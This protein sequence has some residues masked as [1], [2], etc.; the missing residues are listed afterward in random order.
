[1]HLVRVPG[2]VVSGHLGIPLVRADQRGQDPDH[3]GLP[4]T[5][6]P[7]QPEHRPGRH[8][9][10][11]PGQRPRATEALGQPLGS[12]DVHLPSPLSRTAYALM[13]TPYP[14]TTLYAMT[15]ILWTRAERLPRGP[16]PSLSRDQ[17]AAA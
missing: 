4:G 13:R 10:V 8:R 2:H 7:E 9:Q 3:R 17:I 16:Q 5:V 1:A 14:S 11:Q 6:R 15:E 12:D